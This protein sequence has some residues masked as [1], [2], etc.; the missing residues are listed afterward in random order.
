MFLPWDFIIKII[1]KTCRT[2]SL[3]CNK[4]TNGTYYFKDQLQKEKWLKKYVLR[5]KKLTVNIS[6]RK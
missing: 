2:S 5:N 1:L 6:D 4:I 3:I